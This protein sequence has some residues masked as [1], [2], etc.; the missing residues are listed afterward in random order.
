MPS[1]GNSTFSG[2]VITTSPALLRAPPYR[3]GAQQPG[4]AQFA[5]H[6]PFDE[7]HLHDDLGT[8]P[9]RPNA[10]QTDGLG[11]RRLRDL[12]RIQPCRAV[13]AAASCRSR[14][15]PCPRRRSPR[16]RSS[17]PAARPGRRVPPCGSVKPPTTSSCDASHF[18]FSQWG[19]RRCS[20]S[21]SRRLAMTPSQP[22]LQARSHG[23]ASVSAVPV[24]GAVE[25]QSVQHG[26]ALV[27][28]QP[29]QSRPSSHRRSN[30]W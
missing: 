8:H 14:C 21:E 20:Y 23:V 12:D 27:E 30:T 28:R 26:A 16:P 17:P 1:S 5:M 11:K 18:I 7:G 4:V 15:R 3:C 13:R 9:M 25:R 6:R 2:C 10:R 24:L 19:E 22:S 29:R